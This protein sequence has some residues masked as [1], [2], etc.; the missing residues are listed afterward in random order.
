[1]RTFCDRRGVARIEGASH[2]SCKL[3]NLRR[4]VCDFAFER[5]RTG[6]FG[7]ETYRVYAVLCLSQ[8]QE[9]FM[10][11]TTRM[12]NKTT[13]YLFECPS[14]YSH[15]TSMLDERAGMQVSAYGLYLRSSLLQTVILSGDVKCS[16]LF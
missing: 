10:R 1:M 4:H 2:R 15:D 11:L 8:R 7:I 14:V 12:Y 16:R 3:Q 6:R 13:L 5:H 9:S